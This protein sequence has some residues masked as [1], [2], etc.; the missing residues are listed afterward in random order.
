MRVALE[1]NGNAAALAEAGW[2]AGP[3]RSRLIYVTVGTGI[4]GGIILDGKLYRGVDGA[5]PEVGHQVIDL[6]GPPCSCGFR[7]CWESLAAGPAMVTW[8]ESHAPADYPHRQ[9]IT[10]KR[11][12]ELA[13]QG[14]SLALQAVEHEAYYLGLG[15]ANLINLF[16]PDAIVLSGGV[17]KSAPLFTDRIRAVIRS[18]CRFVPAEKTE[19]MLASLG[20]DTISSV[21][22]VCGI[23]AL[24]GAGT[25]CRANAE[26]RADKQELMTRNRYMVGLVFLT[27]FVISLLTNILGPIIPDIISSFHV[28]LTAAGFLAFSFFIAYGVMSIPAGFLVERYTE[29]P[30]MVFAFLAATLG[31]LLFALWPQYRVAVASLFVIGAGMATLQVA[32]NPLLRVSGGEEHYAFN[33]ALAQLIFGSASFISPRIYSYLV[34][35]LKQ[36]QTRTNALLDLLGKLTPAELPWASIYWFFGVCALGM[37]IMLW[38]CKFPQVHYTDEERP[39]SQEMYRELVG[40]PVVWMYFLAMFAYVGCEQGTADWMSKFL[41]ERYGFDPH[42]TAAAAVSWFWGLMTAGCLIG[43]LLLKLLDSRK[44][45]I[46][47]SIGALLC[48]S[49]ALYGPANI[50]LVAFPLV[51]LFASVMWPII[52]SLALNSVAEYHGSFTGILNTGIIGGAIVPIIIG[53]IGDH[54]G[55]RNGL[56]F[57]Y[58]T[59]GFVLSVGFWAKPLIANATIN[60]KKTS[61]EVRA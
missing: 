40:Q 21:R 26:L 43:M 4:G 8:L 53:R 15:L 44:V 49:V 16:T 23:I 41:S 38:R 10:G 46:G 34:L 35:H 2:G 42:T 29:K 28:S 27:F 37:T 20:G 32:I 30:V 57:L 22:R 13:R 7:G 55:L 14:D 5:H 61:A 31:S 24:D 56:A 50:S 12:C 51:G 25:R 3:N 19:L 39:G 48:V 45:L 17:M 58:L 9:G 1:N 54:L 6:A 18:G 11:I 36:P 60:L 47:A 52:V 59:F 33:S